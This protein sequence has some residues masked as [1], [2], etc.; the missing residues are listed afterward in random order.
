[1][2]WLKAIQTFGPHFLYYFC[3]WLDL[4]SELNLKVDIGHINYHINLLISKNKEFHM[5]TS[6]NLRILKG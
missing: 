1:M 5:Q 6:I 2:K 3:I 4:V